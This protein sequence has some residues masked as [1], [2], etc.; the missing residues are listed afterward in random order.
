MKT[1]MRLLLMVLCAATLLVSFDAEAQF[2]NCTPTDQHQAWIIGPD[3]NGNWEEHYIQEWNCGGS[4][5]KVWTTTYH[6]DGQETTW[7]QTTFYVP[8][9]F[10]QWI[11]TGTTGGWGPGP[12]QQQPMLPEPLDHNDCL[13]CGN[14]D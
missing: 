4:I 9:G 2:E 3:E 5:Y 1:P 10:G 11:T 12:T 8:P 6:T 7:A 13:G 14:Y